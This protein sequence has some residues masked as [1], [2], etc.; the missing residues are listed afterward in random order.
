[1]LEDIY[2]EDQGGDTLLYAGMLSI[3][4]NL[5]SLT[6]REIRLNNI[7]LENT[8]AYVDRPESDSAFNF[9]YILDA[10]AGDSTAVPDTLE[11]KGWNF[12]LHR[13]SLKDIR[14]QYHDLLLGNHAIASLGEFDLEMSEFDLGKN[15]FGV[16]EV[17]LANTIA[18]FR[19]TKLPVQSAKAEKAADSTA[20]LALSLKELSLTNVDLDYEQSAIGQIMELEV[21]EFNVEAEEIDLQNQEVQL[22]RVG[23][24][25]SFIAYRQQQE[26]AATSATADK[27]VSAVA[28]PAPWKISVGT[29]DLAN[30]EIQYEN[31]A[32]PARPGAVDFNHLSITGFTVDAR[33]IRYRPENIHAELR[34]LSFREQS[35]FSLQTLSGK[36]D[37]SENQAQLDNIILETANSRLSMNAM[38][39]FPSLEDL[40]NNWMHARITSQMDK[41]H[42][43]VKDVLFFQPTLLDSLPLSLPPTA[44]LTID[45]SLH[46]SVNDL[47][48]EHL[49]FGMLSETTLRASGEIAGLPNADNLRMDLILDKFYSTATDLEIVFPDTLLPD[50][51]NLPAWINLE[52]KFNGTMEKAA[53]TS[54][55]TSETGSI[56]LDGSM[57]LDSASAMRGVDVAINIRDFDVGSVLGKADSIMDKLEMQANSSYQRSLARGNV[58]HAHCARR[59]V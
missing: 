38:V 28:S 57:N 44:N 27:N 24:Q 31:L 58:W 15:R 4:T 48:I 7:E 23:L 32:A 21:G 18:K 14:L 45:A 3:N 49:V 47:T 19:Q 59:T 2:L 33:N 10:F 50:S 34:M 42:I 16:E 1:M 37:V 13:L 51:M 54:L 46:G 35:G 6:K 29:L 53:F 22:T 43:N 55:L 9:T 56:D 26:D 12:S 17:A 41:S 39:D 52:A 11:Q 25:E 20:A 5:W 36:V 30:N 8:I 40:G